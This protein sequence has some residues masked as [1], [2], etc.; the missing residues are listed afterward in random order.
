TLLEP[1]M[2]ME[3]VVPEEFMGDIMG[4]L[5]SRRGRILGTESRGNYQVIRATVPQAEILQYASD[6]QSMTG[7][8]GD[9]SLKLAAYEEVPAQ[10]QEKIIA[11]ARKEIE[12]DEED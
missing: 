9:F 7:G 3:V 8:R 1:I 4:D 10:I 12:E 2:E 5:S 6:L 11:E